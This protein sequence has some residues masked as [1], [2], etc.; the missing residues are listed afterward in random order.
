MP[1]GRLFQERQGFVT[2]CQNFIKKVKKARKRKA[3]GGKSKSQQ[4][5]IG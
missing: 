3:H 1:Q 5:A 2:F 4:F